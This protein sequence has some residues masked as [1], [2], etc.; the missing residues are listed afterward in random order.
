MTGLLKLLATA[1]PTLV[2]GVLGHHAARLQGLMVGLLA[3][4]SERDSW[5]GRAQVRGE[6]RG[7]RKDQA[8]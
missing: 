4:F 3:K 5:L 1:D 8:G 6:T 2:A 7:F